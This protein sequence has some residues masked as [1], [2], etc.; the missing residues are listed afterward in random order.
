MISNNI[1][2]AYSYIQLEGVKYIAYLACCPGG[3]LIAESSPP[4][5]TNITLV[6]VNIDR[7]ACKHA[8]SPLAPFS[9]TDS[10][11]T[12]IHGRHSRKLP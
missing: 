1:S 4:V 2:Q 3:G 8:L 9:I 6:L 7:I 12:I 11:S 5:L 10:T